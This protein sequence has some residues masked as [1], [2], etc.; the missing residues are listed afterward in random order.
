MFT[1]IKLLRQWWVGI[2]LSSEAERAL[3]WCVTVRMWP[4]SDI[5]TINA[6]RLRKSAAVELRKLMH[7]LIDKRLWSL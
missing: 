3:E 5:R 2:T 7:M 4:I 1:V 6:G